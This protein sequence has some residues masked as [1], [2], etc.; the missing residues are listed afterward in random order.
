MT[1]DGA[2]GGGAGGG[3]GVGGWGWGRGGGGMLGLV[4]SLCPRTVLVPDDQAFLRRQLLPKGVG[5]ECHAL[6]GSGLLSNP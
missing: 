4:L 3:V 1:V 6:C 5:K 2:G